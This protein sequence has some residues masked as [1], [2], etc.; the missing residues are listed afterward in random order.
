MLNRL[1]HPDALEV[2][3]ILKTKKYKVQRTA[4]PLKTGNARKFLISPL[5][6]E[7]TVIEK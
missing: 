4:A 3:R 7:A 2:K 6:L 1:N 5:A